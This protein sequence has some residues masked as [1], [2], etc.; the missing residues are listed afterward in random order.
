LYLDVT[1]IAV[2]FLL[3]RAWTPQRLNLPYAA[4]T[5]GMCFVMAA[6]M[7]YVVTN[8]GTLFRLRLMVAALLWMLPLAILR[9]PEAAGRPAITDAE[10][11]IDVEATGR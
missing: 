6:L 3:R 5:G 8:Y 4:F 2:V 10:A 11:P 7:A 1:V 9:G